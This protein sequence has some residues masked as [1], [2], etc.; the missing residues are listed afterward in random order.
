M[1][2]GGFFGGGGVEGYGEAGSAKC[3]WKWRG[4]AKGERRLARGEE[5][6]GRE[7]G[8]GGGSGG[9]GQ[10][11][12]PLASG[13]EA[14]ARACD[15]VDAG[16]EFTAWSENNKHG[17]ESSATTCYH[18]RG[19]ALGALCN[20]VPLSHRTDLASA[21]ALVL[22]PQDDE[23]ICSMVHDHGSKWSVIAGAI[24]DASKARA[25]KGLGTERTVTGKMCRERYT[26]LLDPSLNHGP[27][28]AAEQACLLSVRRSRPRLSPRP[29]ADN[30]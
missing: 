19:A 11:E 25:A 29:S 20:P 5:D 9:G 24:C 17:V 30:V 22:L 1:R 18:S 23:M 28:T 14:E 16:G 15:G 26:N 7:E 27:W 13:R 8:Q 3:R 2:C 21:Y 12:R 10:R 4:I 6:G